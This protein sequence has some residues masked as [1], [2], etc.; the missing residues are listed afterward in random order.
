MVELD[1]RGSVECS[2][3][4]ATGASSIPADAAEAADAGKT[5]ADECGALP[6]EA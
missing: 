5:A 3:A 2:D 6:Y 4:E 1:E